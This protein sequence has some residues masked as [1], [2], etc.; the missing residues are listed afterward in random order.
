MAIYQSLF[1][2]GVCVAT[3]SQRGTHEH[4]RVKDELVPNLHVIKAMQS[5]TSKGVVKQTYCWRHYYWTLTDSGIQYIR[6]FLHLPPEVVPSTLRRG[7]R[8]RVGIGR[9]RLPSSSAQSSSKG[10]DYSR[11]AYRSKIEPPKPAYGRGKDKIAEAGAGSNPNFGF[12]RQQETI[13]FRGG[14]RIE[15][16]TNRNAVN[17]YDPYNGSWRADK[18]SEATKKL[19]SERARFHSSG[20]N[21]VSKQKDSPDRKQS[22]SNYE[23]LNSNS[24]LGKSSSSDVR[25]VQH[26]EIHT[27]TTIVEDNYVKKTASVE[28]TSSYKEEKSEQNSRDNKNEKEENEEEEEDMD[29]KARRALSENPDFEHSGFESKID[30]GRG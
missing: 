4:I 12:H 21:Q 19:V 17:G 6:D 28:I 25:V 26:R 9:G 29:W 16:E 15:R 8:P 30:E 11:S 10:A 27:S 13:S 7:V 23:S 18:P 22:A 24:L 5:L 1:E 2:D 3:N 20:L 14:Y